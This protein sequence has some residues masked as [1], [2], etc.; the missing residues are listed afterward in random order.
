MT[1]RITV[2]LAAL[3]LMLAFAAPASAAEL[4][5]SYI[6]SAP[7]SFVTCLLINVTNKDIEVEAFHGDGTLLPRTTGT[8]GAFQVTAHKLR[9]TSTRSAASR[10][11][12]RT[13]FGRTGRC[14]ASPNSDPSSS[15]RRNSRRELLDM[16][17]PPIWL[18]AAGRPSPTKGIPP[19]DPPRRSAPASSL[20]PIAQTDAPIRGAADAAWSRP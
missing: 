15:Y 3:S 11:D 5:T 1:K 18:D 2:F 20:C 14:L 9:S 6:R 7:N 8:L 12:P 16:V 19:F 10:S 4:F 13:A 17:A